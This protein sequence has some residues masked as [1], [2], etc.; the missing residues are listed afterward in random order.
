MTDDRHIAARLAAKSDLM[1]IRMVKS[2]FE[3]RGFPQ[4]GSPISYHLNINP[5]A[6]MAETSDKFV[7]SAEF[8]IEIS[9]DI[10]DETNDIARIEFVLVGMYNIEEELEFTEEEVDA[11]SKS[12]GIFALYPYAREYVQSVTSRLGLPALTLGLHKVSTDGKE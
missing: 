5:D 8:T 4:N 6:K 11:F 3:H 2:S 1:D 10:E 12:T 7:M 9:Q